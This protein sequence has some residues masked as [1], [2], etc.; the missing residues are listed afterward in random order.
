MPATGFDHHFHEARAVL[1][2]HH[3][4]DLKMVGV[5][6]L[7]CSRLPAGEGIS[8][9]MKFEFDLSDASRLFRREMV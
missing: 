6:F 1:G 8:I 3:A 2:I 7:R 9:P 5:G 4:A